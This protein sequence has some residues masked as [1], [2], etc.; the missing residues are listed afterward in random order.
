MGVC[1]LLLIIISLPFCTLCTSDQKET[2]ERHTERKKGKL[3]SKIVSTYPWVSHTWKI[4]AEKRERGRERRVNP[5]P[6]AGSSTVIC[7][8]Q[9][10]CLSVLD[11]QGQLWGWGSDSKP[12]SVKIGNDFTVASKH[13]HIWRL[14]ICCH[15]KWDFI[16]IFSGCTKLL[17]HCYVSEKLASLLLLYLLFI[18]IPS[19]PPQSS[20]KTSYCRD[21]AQLLNNVSIWFINFDSII[22]NVP[23]WFGQK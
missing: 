11:S 6:L 14:F 20:I 17:Q 3:Y 21:W 7:A 12:E 5:W 23:Y 9:V 10:M 15:S 4:S 2:R 1:S 19:F 13:V 8:Y 18:D 22:F 16:L